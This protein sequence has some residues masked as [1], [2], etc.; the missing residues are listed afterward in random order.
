M[1]YNINVKIYAYKFALHK[2]ALY[3]CNIIKTSKKMENLES[4]LETLKN[5]G[6][7]CEAVSIVLEILKENKIGKGCKISKS[8]NKIFIN[9][10]IHKTLR[11]R[12]NELELSQFEQDKEKLKEIFKKYSINFTK[13]NNSGGV[14][15]WVDWITL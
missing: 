1:S 5:L 13:I 8:S 9:Y 2:Y 15:I 3:I 10:P 6:T 14:N 4:R 7:G 11:P 12:T